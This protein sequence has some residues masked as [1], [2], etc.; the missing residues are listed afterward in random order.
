MP[1]NKICNYFEQNPKSDRLLAV[2]TFLTSIPLSAADPKPTRI[3][4]IVPG[5]EFMVTAQ[6][7]GS[8][9]GQYGSNPW[10]SIA[11]P[12]K[13]IDFERLVYVIRTSMST[14]G[15][16]KG[17]AA[18]RHEGENSISMK[19]LGDDTFLREC[20][21]KHTGDWGGWENAKP[22]QRMQKLL[23]RIDYYRP[24][25]QTPHPTPI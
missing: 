1:V 18:V 10:D 23:Q 24:P 2:L 4:F 21:L 19:P 12:V 7:D 11:L 5:A 3:E 6:P 8:V 14:K 15:E 17:M 16:S 13:S 20:F 25:N 9:T 22:S